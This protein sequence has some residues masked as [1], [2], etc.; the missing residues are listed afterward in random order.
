MRTASRKRVARRRYP[1]TGRAIK[2]A[3]SPAFPLV[4][5]GASA[6]GLEAFIDLLKRLPADTG[7]GFVLIQH[8]DPHHESMLAPLL[9]RYTKM[10]VAQASN[11]MRVLPNRLYVIP[12]NTTMIIQGGLLRLS[13]RKTGRTMPIDSFLRSAAQEQA[14]RAIGVVLSGIG[15][16]GSLGFEAMKATGGITFAQTQE[17]AKYGDMPHSAVATGCV[18]AVL[19]PTEIAKELARISRHSYSTRQSGEAVF[20]KQEDAFHQ[21]LSLLRRASGVNFH[22]YKE[23]TLMRRIIRRMA[24]RR[25]EKLELYLQRLKHDPQ[26]LKAL[27]QDILIT[28][29]SFFRDPDSFSALR[30][31]VFPAL[32]KSRSPDDPIRVWV[33]GCSSGEEVYS[34]AI[35]LLEFLGPRATSAPIQFFGTDINEAALER[36]RAGLYM[37]N[38]S[39]DVSAAR[40][41]RFFVKTDRGYQISKSIRE[42]CIFAKQDLTAD[43]PFSRMDL[44]SCRNVLIYLGPVLQK[45]A[46]PMF[47]YALKPRGFLLLGSSETVGIFEELFALVDKSHKIYTKKVSTAAGAF[48]LPDAVPKAMEEVPQ[49]FRQPIPRMIPELDLQQEMDRLLLSDYATPAVAVS[50]QLEL[51]YSRGDTSPYLSLPPGKANVNLLRMVHE[52]LVVDLRTALHQAKKT[53][54]PVRKERCRF[55][56]KEGLSQPVCLRVA[57]IKVAGMTHFLV[58]FER[59]G[60]PGAPKEKLLSGRKERPLKDGRTPTSE[61]AMRRQILQLRQELAATKE[62]LQATIEEQEAMNEELKSANEEILSSNEELQS[63]NEELQTAKEELQSANEELRTVNEEVREQNAELTRLNNDLSN[64]L[65]SVN[66][67]VVMLSGDLRVRRFTPSAGKVLNLIPTDIGRPLSDIKPNI[68]VPDLQSLITDVVENLTIK[69]RHVQDRQGRR[70]AMRIRPYRTVDNKIDGAVLVLIDIQEFTFHEKRP[71]K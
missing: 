19:S 23:T 69:E 62:Y 25:I 39:L 17:M 45:R 21:I 50:E 70:Y 68:D 48:M 65:S 22:Y 44:I 27:Y 26:E 29:T 12:P 10:P 11:G 18:D 40:L 57:P 7:M 46:F 51:L 14:G 16:D 31:R 49:R 28:V 42:A 55:L 63:T 54:L 9:S 43:P 5:I 37:E 8:L 64:L 66:I 13:M 34:I 59:D 56:D 58:V 36:A 24:L 35:S 61:A 4:T 52:G 3:L 2:R 53:G 60:A 32:M 71:K 47:H 1:P 20:A 33:P 30:R 15:S 41:R 67:P 38:I 6:G